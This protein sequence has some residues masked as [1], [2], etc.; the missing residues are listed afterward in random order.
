MLGALLLLPLLKAH[1]TLCNII[2]LGNLS[3]PSCPYVA[4]P[5]QVSCSFQAPCGLEGGDTLRQPVHEVSTDGNLPLVL[6]VQVAD[7]TVDW[8]SLQRR[9]YNGE[10]PSRT[11]RVKRRDVIRLN[12]VKFPVKKF[13]SSLIDSLVD[14]GS[15]TKT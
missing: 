11:W 14:N 12:L 6:S 8:L 2:L 7:F 4:A 5:M 10:I 9:T 15:Q 1:L 3:A 13:R